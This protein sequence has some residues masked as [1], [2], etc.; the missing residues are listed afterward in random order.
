MGSLVADR[1][2]D[3][4]AARQRIRVGAAL[5]G[6]VGEEQQAAAAGR[7]GRSLVD[8]RP[9]LRSR[10]Q[11]VA[12]PAQAAGGRQHHG[13]HVPAPGHRVAEGVDPAGRL[14]E[15]RRRRR[16]RHAGGPERKRHD[17]LVHRPGPDSI[18]GLVAAAGNDRS[19]GSQPRGGGARGAHDA[20]HLGSLEGR[21]QPGR[22]D[23]QRGHTSADQLRAARSKRIV[24][25]PSALSIAWSPVRRS[26]T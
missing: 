3:E 2:P 14:H 5:A 13:H 19:A 16:E 4:R 26:R 11:R 8:E 23:P 10:G 9:E 21:R 18:R 24:P 6:E 22:V 25:A 12:E 7:R 20:R 15:R 17:A 1:Q